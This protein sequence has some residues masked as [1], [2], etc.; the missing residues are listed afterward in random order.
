MGLRT[1]RLTIDRGSLPQQHRGLG[2]RFERQSVAKIK[3]DGPPID[4]VVI[5]PAGALLTGEDAIGPEPRWNHV[6]CGLRLKALDGTDVQGG[7]QLL[8]T[9]RRFIGM[10][11]NGTQGG[12]PPLALQKTGSVFCFTLQRDDA[13]LPEMKK[14]RLTPSDFAFRSKEELGL[15]FVFVV[16]SAAASIANGKMSYWYDKNMLYAMSKEGRDHLLQ[17]G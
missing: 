6:V 8:I 11:E 2:I 9:G 14:H 12:A 1:A 5:R 15:G 13:Y 17:Q 3:G 7:G 16:F 10:I 4:M